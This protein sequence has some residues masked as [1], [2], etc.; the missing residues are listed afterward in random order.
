MKQNFTLFLL[1]ILFSFTATSQITPDSLVSNIQK[2]LDNKIAA[3]GME[4]TTVTIVMP[5][6]KMYTITS[7]YATK[8]GDPVDTIRKWHW[9]SVTKPLVGYAVLKLHDIGKLDINN[10]I[11]M[12]LN[13]DT[14][15]NVDSGIIIKDL[16]RH[17]G[18]LEEVWTQSNNALWGLVWDN[19][20]AVMCP[21]EI[22]PYMPA[23]DNNRTTHNYASSN[24]YILGFLVEAVSGKD[25]ST[26][27][28]EQIFDVLG[29]NNSYLSSCKAFQMSELNGVWAN[30]ENRSTWDHSS[31]LSSRGGNS[32]L[33]ATSMDVAKFYRSYYNDKLLKKELMDSLRIPA[34]GSLED[35]GTIGCVKDVSRLHGY[36]THFYQ[37]IMNSGDTVMLYGHGGNGVNNSLSYH[38]PK[39]N[40]TLVFATN[41]FTVTNTMGQLYIEL[42]CEIYNNLPIQNPTSFDEIQQPKVSVYPNP[43]A[44]VL[45]I[46]I[47]GF[48]G[49]QS[50]LLIQ[51]IYGQTI[52]N[53]NIST[54]SNQIS[55]SNFSSGIY[56][57]EVVFDG[58]STKGRFLKQ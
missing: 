15:M 8:V 47:D 7:G 21:W 56:L 22:L 50:H 34:K 32:A 1:Y 42:F 6:D 11:G 40:I 4:G 10:A 14:I 53:I 48:H 9:A 29:M 36:E 55:L 26:F 37:F 13:T 5:D 24:S 44:D 31:Y 46:K 27:F 12:Y 25:L 16:L 58:V 52:L 57:Y 3:Y 28:K 30:Q 33:I 41:D 51:N 19:R 43:A 45:N 54:S 39:E 17:T 2:I 35:F 23:P 20:S 18:P 38:W 49:T